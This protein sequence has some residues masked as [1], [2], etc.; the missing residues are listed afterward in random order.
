MECQNL[1][2]EFLVAERDLSRVRIKVLACLFSFV[3]YGD[4][5][6]KGDISLPVETSDVDLEICWRLKRSL[7]IQWMGSSS[8]IGGILSIFCSATSS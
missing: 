1:H 5:G 8:R 7:R 6:T 2:L 4:L 3:H